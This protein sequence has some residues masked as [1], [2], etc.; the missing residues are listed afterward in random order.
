LKSLHKTI[1]KIDEDME[2]YV[3]N[4][5]VSAFMICV[6]E[7]TDLKCN[8][9]QV[10]ED[11]TVLLVPYAPHIAEELWEILGYESGSVSDAEFP[12]YNEEYLIENTF[13]YPVSFNGKMRFKAELPTN[14]S[15]DDVEKEVLA[16]EKAQKYLEG[17]S[18]KKVI[19]VPGRIVNIVV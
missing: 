6:N 2:R 12:K 8:N 14:M 4:T 5:A 7:L 1:K 16:M 13:A 17:K 10:L 11:L 18:P 19:V 9:K 3:F 15:K